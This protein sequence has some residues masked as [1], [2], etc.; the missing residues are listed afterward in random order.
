MRY[1]IEQGLLQAS[2]LNRTLVLPSF[3]YVR[4]CEYAIT[5][6]NDY[7]T[8]VNKGDAVGLDEW[9]DWPKEEQ[10][11]WRLPIT[12]MINM[13]KIREHQPVVTVSEFLRLHG[14]SPVRERSNGAW[15]RSGYHVNP[16]I[17]ASDPGHDSASK[18]SLFVVQN[19]WYDPAKVIR[20]DYI[21]EDMKTRGG[22]TIGSANS[23]TKVEQV[24]P[25]RFGAWS[26]TLKTKV[27][28]LLTAKLSGDDGYLN[29]D[30]VVDALEEAKVLESGRITDAEIERILQSNGWE[31]MH[32]FEGALGMD[33]V[34][35]VAVPI[36][37]AVPR[38]S[39]RSWRDFA[40]RKEDVLLLEGE[41]HLSR[42]PVRT[43]KI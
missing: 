20:V 22:W 30:K 43:A 14:I 8:V 16:P 1:I 2:L 29:W 37:Q 40:D 5:V 26:D 10:L 27:N 33:Y 17:Y 35:H 4:H 13:T 24:M 21:P 34:K 12:N 19:G 3:V 18:P 31:V 36:K 32:T 42:K 38:A 9:R 41:T 25:G 15:D 6:C 7:A 23:T 28:K 11:N 39:L